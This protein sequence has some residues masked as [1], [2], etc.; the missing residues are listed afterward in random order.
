MLSRLRGLWPI[1]QF[2]VFAGG[3]WD[4]FLRDN[5]VIPPVLAVL[6][7][8]VFS[9]IVVGSFIGEPDDEPVSNRGEVAQSEDG[10][11]PPA[12]EIENPNVE[13]YAAYQSKDPFRPLF[14]TTESAGADG[15]ETG[16]D[17]TTG[18]EDETAGNEDGSGGDSSGGSGD[19][20]GTAD[21]GADG[22]SSGGSRGPDGGDAS[23]GDPGG[24]P[25]G[26]PGAADG[27]YDNDDEQKA[28]RRDP[29]DT[30]ADTGADDGRDRTPT[31]QT[32]RRQTPPA[33]EDDL[34]DSGGNLDDPY[35]TYGR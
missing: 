1:R 22:G 25:G 34:F 15:D 31:P 5:K 24:N 6:A 27:Q 23:R 17:G 12:P 4:T 10:G 29:T 2:A 26:D 11:Q 35:G 20:P 18:N 7:L 8:F 14:E 30:G 28:P 21:D 13:S 3:V 33:P 19:G 9:W 16:G 32:P